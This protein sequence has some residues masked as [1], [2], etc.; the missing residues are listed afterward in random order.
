MSPAQN[1]QKYYK[2]C[3]KTGG[4]KATERI[5]QGTEELAYLDRQRCPVPGGDRVD[6]ENPPRTRGERL[7]QRQDAGERT[8]AAPAAGQQRL[9]AKQPPALPPIE[10]E[11]T[12]GFRVVGRNNLQTTSSP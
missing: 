11:T 5:E 2:D 9:P 7:P 6:I 8:G 3:H 12:D 10:Y 4:K 1:S